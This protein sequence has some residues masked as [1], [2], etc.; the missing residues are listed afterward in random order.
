MICVSIGRTRHS[1]MVQE[2]RALV[3]RGAE[4]VEY[5]LDWLG[6]QAPHQAII[7]TSTPH[8]T[9]LRTGRR[10]VMPP[11][12][13]DSTRAAEL[14]AGVPVTYLIVDQLAFLDVSRRYGAPV[15]RAAAAEWPLVSA[16][17]D[18]GPRIYR[19]AE[20]K[21]PFIGSK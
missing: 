11:Y 7:A 14:L 1:M 8:L 15:P 6:R 17:S 16:T 4:L 9:Y 19:R 3:E 12:E 10:A 5:R 18:S 21:A 2:H 20:A 13:V